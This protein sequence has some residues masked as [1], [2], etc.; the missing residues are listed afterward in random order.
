[1][2][3]LTSF[4]VKPTNHSKWTYNLVISY[5]YPLLMKIKW[6]T[7]V[8]ADNYLILAKRNSVLNSGIRFSSYY[9]HLVSTTHR[10]GKMLCHCLSHVS[11]KTFV[12]SRNCKQK[13]PNKINLIFSRKYIWSVLFQNFA[14]TVYPGE[15]FSKLESLNLYAL[16]EGWEES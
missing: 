6:I 1:M 9:A 2:F 4:T 3:F 11:E 5:S 8:S 15:S 13:N 10:N 16:S 14:I 7:Q 12:K